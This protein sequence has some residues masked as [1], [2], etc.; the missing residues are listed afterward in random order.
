MTT[1]NEEL[2]ELLNESVICVSSSYTKEIF[3]RAEYLEYIKAEL[4]QSIGMHLMKS[5]II[6][7]T[8]RDDSFDHTRKIIIAKLV[9]LNKEK[10]LKFIKELNNDN[11]D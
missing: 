8:E 10:Y 1:L 6:E 5:G 11:T 7:F 4:S 9:T 2:I 3:E